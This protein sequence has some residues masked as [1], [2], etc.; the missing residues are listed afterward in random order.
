MYDALDS[1]I[2][3]GNKSINKEKFFNVDTSSDWHGGGQ[4]WL[5]T[6]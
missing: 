1:K 3:R 6:S 4:I 2:G 5:M